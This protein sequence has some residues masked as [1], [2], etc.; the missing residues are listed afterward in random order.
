MH[1]VLHESLRMYIK[2]K[3][4]SKVLNMLVYVYD[5]PKNLSPFG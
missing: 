3:N 2:K 1:F 5:G 4:A